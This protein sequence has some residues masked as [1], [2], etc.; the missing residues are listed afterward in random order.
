MDVEVGLI[1]FVHI[2]LQTAL[3]LFGVAHKDKFVCRSDQEVVFLFLFFLVG[4]VVRDERVLLVAAMERNSSID[5]NF[6]AWEFVPVCSIAQCM[7]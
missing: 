4:V 3:L 7:P 6:R 5:E 1:L 2:H